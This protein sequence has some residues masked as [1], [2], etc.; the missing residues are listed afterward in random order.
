VL[1]LAGSLVRCSELA[2]RPCAASA[3]RETVSA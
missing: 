3:D 1:L 2:D